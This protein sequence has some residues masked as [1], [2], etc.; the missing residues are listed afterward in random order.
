MMKIF[1]MMGLALL[2]STS[3]RAQ[4]EKVSFPVSQIP[5]TYG[6]NEGFSRIPR[7]PIYGKE[8]RVLYLEGLIAT[9]KREPQG[10]NVCFVIVKIHLSEDGK[11]LD[12]E[13]WIV[14]EGMPGFVHQ[15]GIT[16]ETTIP[17]VFIRDEGDGETQLL[18]FEM[19]KEQDLVRLTRTK[20]DKKNK[21]IDYELI[22]PRNYTADSYIKKGKRNHTY[23]GDFLLPGWSV[24]CF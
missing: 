21:I 10:N 3:S 20:Y 24:F 17:Y 11:R 8:Q 5:T 1:F 16:L 14:Q 4:D 18:F 19:N 23:I 22:F 9:H 12:S 13:N 2:S 7:S 6:L 15:K